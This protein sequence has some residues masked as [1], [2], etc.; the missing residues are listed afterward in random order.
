MDITRFFNWFKR[1]QNLKFKL[2]KILKQHEDRSDDEYFFVS[3]NKNEL[4]LII[5]KL[6]GE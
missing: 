4:R 3:L 5:S 2:E 6:E 1:V